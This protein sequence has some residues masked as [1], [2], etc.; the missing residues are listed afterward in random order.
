MLLDKLDECRV[1][2]DTIIVFT[3][4]HGT[5]VNDNGAF[6]KNV[7]GPR[8][9]CA[10]IPLTFRMPGA[11]LAGTHVQP[12]VLSHDLHATLLDLAGI[13]YPEEI[14]GRSLWPLVTGEIDDL[15]G[16]Q[17]ITSWSTRA[18]VRDREWAM[19]VDTLAAEPKPELFHSAV[20]PNE[21]EDVA[22]DFP[23]VLADRVSALE[24]F[25]GQS[26]PAQYEQQP[27]KRGSCYLHLHVKKR[28]ELGMEL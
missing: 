1:L 11:K 25:I 16:D 28:E 20:D 5:E 22:A 8:E 19:I 3:S 10:R 26:L 2:D 4:D 24:G 14:Q 27:D 7:R 18:C 23:E 15:H 21:S 13:D 9:Y 6:G 17:L 12:Y